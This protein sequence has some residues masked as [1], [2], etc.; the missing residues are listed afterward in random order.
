MGIHHEP[1]ALAVLLGDPQHRRLMRLDF[2]MGDAPSNALLLANQLDAHEGI[3]H[4]FRY[5]VE[6]LS[7]D[8]SIA[9]DTVVDKMV[10]ISLVLDDGSL[11]YFNGYVDSFRFVRTDG[12]F[13]FYEMILL[14]WLAYLR[15]RQDSVVFQDLCLTQ[16]C[17]QVFSRYLQRDYRFRLVGAEKTMTLAVQF[18]ESDYNHL[19]RRLEA[20]G[21]HYWYEHRFDGHT[22]CLGDDTTLA[23]PIHGSA[24]VAYQQAAGAREED[25]LKVWS[26]SRRVSA[27]AV[28][29]GSHDFKRN[30]TVWGQRPSLAAGQ[31]RAHL[32][33]SDYTGAYGF[34][35]EDDGEA[36]ALRR[37]QE[38]DGRSAD[39]YA[40]GNVRALQPRRWFTLT[41]HF[42][43][44]RDTSSYLV[45]RIDHT[46]RNNYQDGQ[47]A[48]SSYTNRLRCVSAQTPW[49]PERQFNS[50]DTRIYGPQTALVVGPPGEEI[51]TDKFGRVRLQF[52]WDRVGAKD[53]KSLCWV[54]V[55]SSWAGDRFGSISLPRIGQEVVVMFMDGNC[56]RPMVIGSV[57]NARNMPPWELPA[58]RTQS[59]ILTRSTL[60]GAYGNANALRFEDMKGKEQLWLHAEKD[61]LTEVENDE[62][63]WVGNDRRKTI[64]RDETSHIKHDRTET[65]DN[66]EIITIHNN[67]TEQVDANE[68]VGIG[69]N[70]VKSI[71]KNRKDDIG[72]NWSIHVGRTKTETVG[73]AYM[74]NVG[75]GRLENVG[76]AYSL[77]VGTMMATMV[78]VNQTTKVGKTISITAGDELSI[79]VGLAK[80]KMTSDGKIFIN[81]SQVS[82]DASGPVQISGKDVDIN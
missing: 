70:R 49:R 76:L 32:E 33:Q 57:Y 14:P 61:Q 47:L 29:V 60:K 21:V 44:V 64:D 24:T 55:M 79:T 80:L 34:K 27:G 25:G 40:E 6:V 52:H 69:G 30:A 37:M 22:L 4:D 77:N 19:H 65:V 62:V 72:K 46:A 10:T 18:R 74:Q 58:N 35:D 82:V 53:E 23:E 59:G 15:H 8:A 11:R 68:T 48:A 28:S 2:P 50:A 13:A 16:L 3:S 12:G 1:A 43:E 73:M 78:G 67:R 39:I 45:V 38:L 5:V 42:G 81:G 17:E 31:G 26:P 7:D 54:R 9:L 75:L 20:A 66:N 36:T 51:Y 71:G 56:D 63:K 41:G